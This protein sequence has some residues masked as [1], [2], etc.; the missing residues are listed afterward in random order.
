[1]SNFINLFRTAAGAIACLAILFLGSISATAQDTGSCTANA[2]KRCYERD[3]YWYDSCGNRG[4]VSQDCGG[5]SLT[6]KYK[7]N[8]DWVQREKLVGDCANNACIK[9]SSWTNVQNCAETN[10]VCVN[11]K[12]SVGDVTPPAISGMSPAGTVRSSTV[13]LSVTTDEPATCRYSWYNKIYDQMTLSFGTDNNLYHTVTTPSPPAGNCIYYVRCRDTMGNVN[14]VPVRITFRYAPPAGT[15]TAATSTPEAEPGATEPGSSTAPVISNLKFISGTAAVNPAISFATDK[16]ANCRYDSV[17]T[18]YDSMANSL[19]DAAATSHNKEITVPDNVLNY[20]IRCKDESGNKDSQSEKL[21]LPVGPIVT[22]LQPQGTVYQS[23]ILL[24]V[25]TNKESECRYSLQDYD[26]DQ[27]TKSFFVAQ[28]LRQ[29]A[30]VELENFGQYLYYIRCKGKNG[31]KNQV[32]S[33]INF[34]YAL[35]P[36]KEIQKEKPAENNKT[37]PPVPVTPEQD[38]VACDKISTGQKDDVCDF[39]INC[40]CDPDCGIDGR[41]V[42]PDCQATSVGVN[43]LGVI[44]VIILLVVIVVAV[45]VF[46]VVKRHG[47]SDNKIEQ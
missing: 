15:V 28:G 42:D 12:C 6:S 2:S 21:V 47:K 33:Q 10:K 16:N 1:M 11:G 19:D 45:P 3:L 5:E 43:D 29:E 17:D 4:D 27:M 7:C 14:P 37:N 9:N 34:E 24:S 25:T 41:D 40:S 13:T 18:D 23:R 38:P 39:S 31:D 22:G 26:F 35:S 8:G 32:S 30:V 36:E 46:L 20:Y 44:V